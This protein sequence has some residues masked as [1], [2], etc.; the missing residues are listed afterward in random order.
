MVNTFRKWDKVIIAREYNWLL[1]AWVD[2]M[3]KEIWK[4]AKIVEIN[5]KLERCLLKIEWWCT[6][7]A[8]FWSLHCLDKF[9]NPN[10]DIDFYSKYL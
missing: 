10:Q 5:F 8:Y 9:K 4:I 2:E 6:P 7:S 1:A 3:G